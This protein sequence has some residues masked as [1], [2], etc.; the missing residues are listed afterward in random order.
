MLNWANS[1]IAANPGLPTIIT[2]HEDLRDADP[3]QGNGGTTTFGQHTWNNLIRQNDQ[4]F[5][6]I[7]GHNHFGPNQVV[8]G[9]GEWRRVDIN[10]E[11]NPVLRVM[12]TFQ[13]W[14][15]FGDGYLR[16]LTIDTETAINNIRFQTYS[17]FRDLYLIDF[18]GPTASQF[19]YDLDFNQRF[20]VIP[21]P[22]SLALLVLGLTTM[23]YRRR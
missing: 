20:G 6:V 2:T 5:M 13:D 3:G 4:I 9:D 15:N 11:G 1:V 10:N 22:A 19:S 7:S 16:L 12:T 21:E 18:I 8:N 14:P 17:P 23:F